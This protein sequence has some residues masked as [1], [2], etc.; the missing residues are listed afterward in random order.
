LV[1]GLGRWWKRLKFG[2]PTV[3]GVAPRGFFIPYRHAESV[4][5][6]IPSYA[7]VEALFA[8]HASGFAAR[9][10][11]LGQY[12]PELAEFGAAPPPAPRWAQDW[13]PRLDAA[14]AYG[15]TRTLAPA[16]IVEIGSGH[17]TRF[18]ARAVTDG[19]LSTKITAIDP[20]PRAVLEGL[21]SVRLHRAV[22]QLA[23]NEVFAALRPGDILSIDSSHILM[24][25][26]DVDLLLNRVLPSLPS[27]I[28]VHIHDMFLPDGYPRDWGWR[29]YN[30]QLGVA[31]LL[32]GGGWDPVFSSHYVLTRMRDLFQATPVSK[33]PLPEGALES[34][35]WLK[36]R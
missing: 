34:S 25:G 29:G 12:G 21:A 36:K 17:S 27:G 8:R 11:D 19:E 20:A 4:T 22:V 7:P 30:E 26:S 16:R 33:L 9:L 18:Y 15:M 35:L 5:D 32:T 14:M 31:A 6:P 1:S 2:L 3:L 13:F 23:P 28:H 10:A 24:P